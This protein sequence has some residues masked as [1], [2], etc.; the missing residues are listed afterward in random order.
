[1]AMVQ[2]TGEQQSGQV[3][4][5]SARCCTHAPWKT[6]PHSGKQT[7]G[8]A[9]VSSKVEQH[10]AQS[11]KFTVT[12]EKEFLEETGRRKINSRSSEGKLRRRTFRLFFR[13]TS[14]RFAIV[15]SESSKK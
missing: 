12:F 7:M 3:P 14:T 4:F 11:S 1:M 2:S 13:A 5:L 15:R 8:I 10:T 9:G 6:C